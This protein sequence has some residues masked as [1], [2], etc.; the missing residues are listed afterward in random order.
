MTRLRETLNDIADEAPPVNLADAAIAGYRRRRRLTTGAAALATAVVL[1]AATAATTV[2]WQ[3]QQPAVSQRTGT[4]P[5]LPAGKVGPLGYAYRTLCEVDAQRNVSCDAVEWRVVTAAGVT[6]RVPQAVGETAAGRVAPISISRDGRM[7]AYYSRQARAHVVRDLVTGAETTSPVTVE[8]DRIGAGSMLVVSDDGRYLVFDPRVGSKY[9]GTLIDVRTGR[10]VPLDGRYEAVGVKGG[11]VELV[12]YVKTDLWLMPVTGGGKPVR[13]KGPHI[14]FNEVSPDGRTVVALHWDRDLREL[15][16]NTLTV[17]DVRT[18]RT[19]RKLA[20][21]GL[22]DDKGGILST[23]P[24]V[25][26]HEFTVV[27]G[28][29]GG[30]FSTYAVDAGTGRARRLTGYRKADSFLVVP[31]VNDVNK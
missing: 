1:A 24:W 20:I 7:L 30:R 6:Y 31:G 28:L 3:G 4:V 23:G 2:P 9:P 10:T 27:Y 13:F 16:D 12:R 22:P 29:F 5:D 26:G 8:E 25:S 15:K 21:R 19:V 17:L 18:G 11:V 14:M